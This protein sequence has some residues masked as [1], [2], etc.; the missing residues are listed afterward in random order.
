MATKKCNRCDKDIVGEGFYAR[1]KFH[2]SSFCSRIVTGHISDFLYLSAGP[3]PMFIKRLRVSVQDGSKTQTRRN[4]IAGK[5]DSRWYQ[6]RHGIAGSI[7]YLREPLKKGDGGY[8]YYRD[9]GAKVLNGFGNQIA[10]RWQKDT[11]PQMFM[12][13]EAARTFAEMIS[14]RPEILQEISERDA[15]AEGCRSRRI[16]EELVS[17]AK[18]DFILLWNGIHRRL[19]QDWYANGLSVWVIEFKV[20]YGGKDD[21]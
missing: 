1:G 6:H 11:L 20:L 18:E 13:K 10:W 2:C 7:R 21:N 8:T 16:G 17:T 12:P 9:D 4:P 15:I 19:G 14:I 3:L 5:P